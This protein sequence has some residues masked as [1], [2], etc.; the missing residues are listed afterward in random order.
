M[1]HKRIKKNIFSEWEADDMHGSGPGSGAKMIMWARKSPNAGLRQAPWQSFSVQI[2]SWCDNESLISIRI[3]EVAVSGKVFHHPLISPIEQWQYYYAMPMRKYRAN[4]SISVLGN[5]LVVSPNKWAAI[6][7][8]KWL[9]C[10]KQHSCQ[11]NTLIFGIFKNNLWRFS[12]AGFSFPMW[13]YVG[14]F[15]TNEGYGNYS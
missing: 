4:V 6:K 9:L 11:A 10:N 2:N 12:K 14:Y 8:N 15:A 3:S 13:G 5:P 7:A 1:V